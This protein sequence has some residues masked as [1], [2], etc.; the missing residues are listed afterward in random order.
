M[1]QTALGVYYSWGVG[2]IWYLLSILF[3]IC[4]LL[5]GLTI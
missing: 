5:L 2:L 3:G 4:Y 1:Q